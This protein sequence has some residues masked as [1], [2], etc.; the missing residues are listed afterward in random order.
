MTRATG[1]I[2]DDGRHPRR[3]FAALR[4]SQAVPA[5][6]RGWAD[7]SAGAP[8]I[9]DQGS[10]SSCAGCG[11]P[12]AAATSL[13]AAGHPLGWVPS[14]DTAYKV[15]RCLDR[16][17]YYPLR[18]PDAYPALEDRGT[19][20]LSVV[21]GLREWG[22]LP[23]QLPGRSDC[24]RDS[25]LR[26]P[27]LRTLAVAG[28]KLLVGAYALDLHAIGFETML[29]LDAGHAVAIGG[30][31]DTRFM[32]QG[33]TGVIGA[34][35]LSDPDGGGHC[36][37]LTGYNRDV[38]GASVFRLRNSWGTGWGDQGCAWVTGAFLRQAWEAWAMRCEP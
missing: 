32:D 7:L 14:V 17:A 2:R 21:Q 16:A 4:Q 23:S 30:W 10:R 33:P 18:T 29:A 25:V 11:V 31:V 3:L 8:P 9:L 36:T 34:Q 5:T 6:P 19:M 35:D 22:T 28:R 38:N 27:D 1:L 37:Y 13:A 12:C 26:E 15:A 20:A 24:T